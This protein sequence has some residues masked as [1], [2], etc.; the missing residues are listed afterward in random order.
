MGDV[1]MGKQSAATSLNFY[2]LCMLVIQVTSLLQ[3]LFSSSEL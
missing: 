1:I 2:S 3:C